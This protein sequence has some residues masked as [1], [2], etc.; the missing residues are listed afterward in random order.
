MSSH[1]LQAF[2][3]KDACADATGCKNTAGGSFL[4]ISPYQLLKLWNGLQNKGL[5]LPG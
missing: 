4:G 1:S 3:K 2:Q 5:T